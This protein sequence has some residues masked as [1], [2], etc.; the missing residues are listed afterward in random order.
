[1]SGKENTDDS[2]FLLKKGTNEARF[3]EVNSLF[4]P[5]MQKV[6]AFK[7]QWGWCPHCFGH[8]MKKE[9]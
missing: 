2:S 6:L 3:D 7:N 4:S 1:V 9:V 8:R 5:S